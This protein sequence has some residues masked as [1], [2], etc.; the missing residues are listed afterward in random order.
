MFLGISDLKTGLS[1][2]DYLIS[3]KPILEVKAAVT[4][5]NITE[6][7]ILTKRN[8]EHTLTAWVEA[9]KTICGEKNLLCLTILVMYSI[10]NKEMI[11]KGL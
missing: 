4:S 5:F 6:F 3:I 11:V 7:N 8:I 10:V 9:M 2:P 1:S